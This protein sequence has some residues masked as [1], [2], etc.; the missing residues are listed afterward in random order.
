MLVNFTYSF[1]SD[2]GFDLTFKTADDPGLSLIKYGQFLYDHLIIFAPSVEGKDHF[3]GSSVIPHHNCVQSDYTIKSVFK[4]LEETSIWRPSQP[5]LMVGEMFWL[6]PAQILVS[7]SK[8]WME[9]V[10][11]FIVVMIL[12]ALLYLC[13]SLP[14]GDPI[15]ELGSE[16]GVEFDE[17]KTAVID[18]HNY[19]VSDPGE[20]SG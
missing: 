10:L 2:R 4:I 12:R 20:V 14:T 3:N 13:F 5:S 15:R 8:Y 19:D 9:M 17:E 7:L 18:H 11:C 6:Q 16:C 1:S